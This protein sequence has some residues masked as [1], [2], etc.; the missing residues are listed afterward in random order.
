MVMIPQEQMKRIQKKIINKKDH[1]ALYKKYLTLLSFLTS[2][3]QINY[4]NHKLQQCL[5]G[6]ILYTNII[7]KQRIKKKIIF[8]KS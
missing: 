2:I 6:F 1:V 4:I 7:C 5:N 8:L 3:K